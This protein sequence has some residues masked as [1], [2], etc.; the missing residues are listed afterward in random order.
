MS[1]KIANVFAKIPVSDS[2]FNVFLIIKKCPPKIK[3]NIG[4]QS[5]LKEDIPLPKRQTVLDSPC[6]GYPK[7]EIGLKHFI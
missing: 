2:A 3:E 1:L 4:G 5:F 6:T 7:D